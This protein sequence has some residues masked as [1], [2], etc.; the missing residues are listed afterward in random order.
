[1]YAC[2][3]HLFPNREICEDLIH[4]V[5]IYL[6]NNRAKLE[7]RSVRDYLYIAIKNRTLNKIR[8][9]K[10]QIEIGEEQLKTS[11][12]DAADQKV[13]SGEIHALFEQ[14]LHT[15]PDKCRQILTMSRKEHLSNKE[16]AERLNLSTK[17]VENQINIGLRK[18][19]EFMGEVLILYFFYNFFG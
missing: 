7:I 4:D 5:F 13:L 10:F 1:M 12:N 9:E 2:A 3:F 6:W 8:S 17:T 11:S 14:G 16:I 15:L 19:R 18:I